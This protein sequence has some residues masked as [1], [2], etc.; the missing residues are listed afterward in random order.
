MRNSSRQPCPCREADKRPEAFRL[1]G[2]R[3]F[4]RS[5]VRLRILPTLGILL[6][7]TVAY[8]FR[9]VFTYDACLARMAKLSAVLRAYLSE[10]DNTLPAADGWYEALGRHPASNDDI[11]SCP[12]SKH[13]TVGCAFNASLG[14]I[15]LDALRSPRNTVLLFE[16]DRGMNAAGGPELLPGEPRH[17][18]RDNYVFADGRVRRLPRK[19]NPDGT[20]AKEPD[21][22]WVI[23]K[24]V[25][26]ETAPEGSA[27]GP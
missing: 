16:T 3:R 10:H 20:W 13:G 26:K 5:G 23:W 4:A 6:L 18:G 14:E 12:E 7:L 8:L 25:L 15:E 24:P 9:P 19:K 21:A 11:V 22:D 27:H 1:W 2:H 17:G